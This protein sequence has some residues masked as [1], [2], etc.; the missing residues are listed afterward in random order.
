MSKEGDR[1]RRLQP[2]T[3]HTVRNIPCNM[4]EGKSGTFLLPGTLETI[5]KIETKEENGS[6][7]E[8]LIEAEPSFAYIFGELP[9]EEEDHNAIADLMIQERLIAGSDGGDDQN[10]RIVF[11]MVLASDDLLD[12]HI[13]GHEAYGLPKDLGRA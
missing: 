1:K 2:T 4:Y 5:H 7:L 8:A 11:A 12:Q 9:H 13:S 10:G 3:G 6:F